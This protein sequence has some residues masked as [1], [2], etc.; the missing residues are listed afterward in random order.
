MRTV[1]KF[2]VRVQ[3]GS[4]HKLIT[5]KGTKLLCV[6]VQRGTICVWGEVDDT[7]PLVTRQI[8]LVGTGHPMLLSSGDYLGTVQLLEG[9]LVLHVYVED[10]MKT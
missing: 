3:N 8:N 7:Q 5:P 6:Q 9:S 1:W 4:M 10:E 2:E